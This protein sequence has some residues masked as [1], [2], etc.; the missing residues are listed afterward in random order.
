MTGHKISAVGING[1]SFSLRE[2]A[3]MRGG[4]KSSSYPL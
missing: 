4:I 2:K 3:R 1:N